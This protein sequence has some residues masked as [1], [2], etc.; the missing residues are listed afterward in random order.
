[1][2]KNIGAAP[3]LVY[4]ESD[5]EPMA[6]TGRHVRSLLDMIEMIDWHF[7]DVPDVHVC[8]N[9]FL[10]Y[11]EGNPRKVISPDVFMV[12]GVSKKDLRTYKTWEQQPYL[13]FVLEL[14]SP[15]TFTRD[16]AEKKTIYEQILRV[17]E[18]YI[19]DP[20]HEIQP[21][22]IGFRLIEGSYEEIEFVEG[23]LP[24]EVLGLDL[25]EHD[26]VLRLYDPVARAWLGPSRERLAEAETRVSE[27]E[28]R[29]EQ[30]ARAR[31]A[32]EAEL[33]KLRETLKRLQTSE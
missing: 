7:R 12:R 21:S 16:F 11:E 4:P 14:A 5:G 27:A 25:G 32:A 19:Y 8:G 24:S 30:E 18:Y 26:G 23:R 13:D 29:I 22:F 31:Q 15:S 33:E 17:K 6:E 1:M 3:T 2:E 9:M 28:T 20:Y 10:Y